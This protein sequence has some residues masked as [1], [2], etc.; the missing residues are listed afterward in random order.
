VRPAR[1]YFEVLMGVQ[2][3]LWLRWKT[4]G[5]RVRVYVPF[6]PEWRAYSQRRLGKNPEILRH[7]IRGMF[8]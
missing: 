8:R 3:P 6:G 2:E 1:Y 5:N 4:A 7:V